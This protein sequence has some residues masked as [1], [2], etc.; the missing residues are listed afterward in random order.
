MMKMSTSESDQNI[1]DKCESP[2]TPEELF[3]QN[4]SEEKKKER[5]SRQPNSCLQ[6][7]HIKEENCN[8]I[9]D[10]PS[11]FATGKKLSCLDENNYF[12]FSF[13][14]SES[15][16][17][18]NLNLCEL[19][20][21][22]LIID[23]ALM[24][25]L[26]FS[27]SESETEGDQTLICPTGVSHQGVLDKE[28]SSQESSWELESDSS[29][30]SSMKIK[31]STRTG[32]NAFKKE[33]IN[34]ANLMASSSLNDTLN[35]N[36][37]ANILSESCEIAINLGQNISDYWDEESYLSE[38]FYEEEIDDEKTHK[39]LNFGDDY[40]NFIDSLSEDQRSVTNL[41]PKRRKRLKK[42]RNQ[43]EA[44]GKRYEDTCSE[45]EGESLSSVILESEKDLVETENKRRTWEKDGFVKKSHNKEYTELLGICSE[46]LKLL[47][48]ILNGN[49][50]I[51]TF[52]SK[53]GIKDLK[54]AICKWERLQNRITENIDK[55]EMYHVLKEDVIT[56]KEDLHNILDSA[57]LPENLDSPDEMRR[58]L[59][60]YEDAITELSMFKSKL[61]NLNMSIHN[62][63][64]ELN[65]SD[66]KPNKT[67]YDHAF[68]LQSDI[69]ELYGTWD[70]AHL[71]T[72]ANIV[73]ASEA[74]K[75]LQSFESLLMKLKEGITQDANIIKE[76]KNRKKQKS[77]TKNVSC[78]SGISDDS[79][80]Y[81]TEN[82]IAVK[83]HQLSRLKLM[84]HGLQE[85][86]PANSQHLR[87][88]QSSL[89]STSKELYDLKKSYKRVKKKRC[90]KIHQK[91]INILSQ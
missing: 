30:I 10:D 32:Y 62:F 21:K 44:A 39:L 28:N 15:E 5:F 64:A 2:M 68:H 35:N 24:K 86:M 38:Y 46:N 69:L 66:S 78:D 54:F 16:P 18:R 84:A 65:T 56:F 6:D 41:E 85:N 13:Q 57:S 72:S 19:Q 8:E 51:A 60:S 67:R 40:R 71:Q 20:N 29:Q 90:R 22:S 49:D 26:E 55:T 82:D 63:L 48:G 33:E 31:N 70:R 83:E 9:D 42:T 50:V 77:T 88:I 4:I 34:C 89:K 79:S 52:V 43:Q 47:C 23:K 25:S 75:K 27:L 81:L 17:E 80:A 74:L 91:A 53:K 87:F 76:R 61:F 58:V 45:N 36:T 11:L 14:S 59:L 73:K 7:S 12:A 1:S 37:E 3:N